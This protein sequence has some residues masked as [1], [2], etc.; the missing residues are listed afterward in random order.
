MDNWLLLL[1]WP[2]NS[3]GARI[4][5]IENQNIILFNF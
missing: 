2:T 3:L 5:F 4:K 1:I